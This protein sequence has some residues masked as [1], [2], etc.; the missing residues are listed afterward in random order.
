MRFAELS[1][2][3]QF[4]IFIHTMSELNWK[5]IYII[6][7]GLLETFLISWGMHSENFTEI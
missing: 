4:S 5:V 1:R 2:K 7:S 6:C 3:I